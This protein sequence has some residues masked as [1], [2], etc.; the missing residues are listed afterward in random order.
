MFGANTTGTVRAQPASSV[1]C[2][3]EKPVVPTTAPVPWRDA[4]GEMRERSFGAREVDQHVRR[5]RRRVGVSADDHAGRAAGALARV[6]ARDRAA[7]DVER[8][9]KREL[10]IGKRRLDQRL[11]HPP[12]GT[13]ERRSGPSSLTENVEDRNPT[14][15]AVRPSGLRS[16]CARGLRG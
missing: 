6:A 12:A 7:G 4:R 3:S 16:T 13:G 11:A 2:A 9:G 1:F 5:C 14:T 15:S 10:P 8:R